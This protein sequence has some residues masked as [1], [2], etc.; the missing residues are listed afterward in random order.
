MMLVGGGVG[1][2][3]ALL[4]AYPLSL[5]DEPFGNILPAAASILFG[6]L[7]IT[8]FSMRSREMTPKRR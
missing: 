3:I 5:L 8:V 2:A 6:Y 1:L 7:G 4:I